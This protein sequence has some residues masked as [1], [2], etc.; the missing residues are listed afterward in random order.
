LGPSGGPHLT[1]ARQ[2]I[3]KAGDVAV[4]DCVERRRPRVGEQ[5]T[6]LDQDAGAGGGEDLAE[7]QYQWSRVSS[8]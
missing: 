3:V 5:V 7:R 8:S 4:V 1:D 6:H 2:W